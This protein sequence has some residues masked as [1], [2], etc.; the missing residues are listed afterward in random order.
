MKI[1]VIGTGYIGISTVLYYIK[2][3]VNVIGIDV[4]TE[5]VKLLNK[6]ILPQKD[7][8]EWLGFEPK[9]FLK[10]AK[11]YNN[12]KI[13]DKEIFDAIFIAVPTEK[14]GT[15][16]FKALDNVI[17]KITSSKNYLTL[18]I[19]EST[20]MP[21]VSANRII[22]YLTNFAIAYRRDWFGDREKN[23][24]TIPRIVGGN[25]EKNTKNAMAVLYKV[26][27]T[28]Y[29]C[30]YKEAELCKAVENSQR[31]LGIIY[32]DQLSFAY[33]DLDI[34]KILQLSGTKW[35]CIAYYPSIAV[36]GY[37][38]NLASKYVLKGSKYKEELTLLKEA[39]KTDENMS[40][41]IAAAIKKKNPNSI[42]ILGIAYLANIKVDI[43]S[44]GTKLLKSFEKQL[45]K[46]SYKIIKVYDSMFSAK[47]IK[48]KTGYNSFKFPEDLDKFEYIFL[49][50]G[51][52]EFKKLESVIWK[53]KT[54]KAKLIFDNVGILEKVDLKCPYSLMGKPQWLEKLQ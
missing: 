39:L 8:L 14:D 2:A 18:T 45:G 31:H 30:N 10:K 42:A 23:L 29:S 38:I 17:N 3:G 27:D 33:P 16:Y 48:E 11:F 7:L 43:L 21:G 1:V 51:H 41:R 53:E 49:M 12:F 50:A 20:L 24:K 34:R 26:C 52:D 9:P 46:E 13:L 35:N 36:G 22:P 6:G 47:E 44:A 5:K 37:C 25:T 54:K 19:I 28:L 15:P 32:T 4:D 40:E